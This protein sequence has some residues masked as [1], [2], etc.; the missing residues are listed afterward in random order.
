MEGFYM[1]LIF[2]LFLIYIIIQIT[3]TIH[4]TQQENTA[5]TKDISETQTHPK[6]KPQSSP[7]QTEAILDDAESEDAFILNDLG[8][9]E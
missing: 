2:L 4:N 7:Q 1:T 3:V 8:D 5:L 9:F 6:Q